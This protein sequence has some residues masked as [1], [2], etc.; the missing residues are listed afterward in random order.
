MSV[1]QSVFHSALLDASVSVPD[2]LLDAADQP[3]GRRFSVYRNNVAVSLTEAL[4]QAFPVI[5]KLLG[6]QNMDGLAGMFLRQH[7]PSSPLMMFYGEAF[8]GFLADLPQLAHLGYLP[9]MA[10][11]ELA[12]RRSYH[13]ADCT[14]APADA[15]NL[16]PED[17][18]RSRLSFAPAMQVMQSDWPVHAIWRFNTEDNAP[19]PEPGPQDVLITRPEYDPIPHLLPVGGAKWISHLQTGDTIGE[20]YEKTAETWPEFDLGTTLAILLQGGAITS[21]TIERLET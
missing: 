17:I 16:S 14:P 11:L 12:L 8:P 5:A 18:M 6:A 20:A 3:A 13:A 4:H 7:P 15:L 9:D 19:K 21:V 1:S 2:G 10:R